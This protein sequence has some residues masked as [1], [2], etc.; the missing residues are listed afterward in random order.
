MDI[1]SASWNRR[2][3]QKKRSGC[4]RSRAD[5]GRIGLMLTAIHHIAIIASDYQRSRRFYVEILGLPVNT[6]RRDLRLA[7]AWL[8]RELD[9][10]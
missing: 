1:L 5:S 8:Q 9:R 3:L 4:P 2:A 7:Q 6:V 10:A